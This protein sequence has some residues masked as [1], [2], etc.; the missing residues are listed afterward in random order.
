MRYYLSLTE[1]ASAS[2]A[3]AAAL[4]LVAVRMD[5]DTELDYVRAYPSPSLSRAVF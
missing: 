1:V 5:K 2:T 3:A 4:A